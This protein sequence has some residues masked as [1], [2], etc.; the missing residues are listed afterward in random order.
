MWNV[1]TSSIPPKFNLYFYV[2][3]TRAPLRCRPFPAERTRSSTGSPR[4]RPW[5]PWTFRRGPWCSARRRQGWRRRQGRRSLLRSKVRASQGGRS[6]GPLQTLTFQSKFCLWMLLLYLLAFWRTE[7]PARPFAFLPPLLWFPER[8]LPPLTPT[9]RGRPILRSGNWGIYFKKRFLVYG[10]S[11]KTI[12]SSCWCQ[13]DGEEIPCDYSA[14]HFVG[15][16]L[17]LPR[18]G[19]VQRMANKQTLTENRVPCSVALCVFC[20]HKK[21]ALEWIRSGHLLL[22]T[23]LWYHYCCL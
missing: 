21:V 9:N 20:R 12:P 15:S 4:W 10:K 8:T 2:G 22:F 18:G 11:F 3:K 5:S 13:R 14:N 17:L 19:I 7:C 1:I 6:G 23:M 16:A